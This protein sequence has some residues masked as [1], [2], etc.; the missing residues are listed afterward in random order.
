[1]KT[2]HQRLMQSLNDSSVSASDL[3]R[4]V[5]VKPSSVSDW[6]SG[7][8]KKIEGENLINVCNALNISAEWLIFGK[9]KA[10]KANQDFSDYRTMQTT[11]MRPVISWVQ[12]GEMC[13]SGDVDNFDSATEW[14]P[15]TVPHSLKCYVLVVQ[16]DS[17]SPEYSEG[18]EIFVDPEVQARHN[19]DVVVRDGQGNATFKRL[20]ITQ[21]GMFLMALNPQ[22]PERYIKVPADTTICGVVIYSGMKRR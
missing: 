12:A 10:F 21:E 3:A 8:T 1:M 14:R 5:K 9:E 19:D 7:K 15:C 13:D 4:L 11:P 22:W 6:L 17:M 2:W 16:G 20:K 18:C